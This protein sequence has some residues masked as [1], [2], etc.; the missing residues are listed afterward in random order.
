MIRL[1]INYIRFQ[2]Q[3]I[4]HPLK[5]HSQAARVLEKLRTDSDENG[6]KAK[7]KL[8]IE[9]KLEAQLIY[10]YNTKY[11]TRGF[12]KRQ[13]DLRDEEYVS[14]PGLDIDE[15]VK[16]FMDEEGN[17]N[18]NDKTYES[19]KKNEE[20]ENVEDDNQP[21][22]PY[23]TPL[24][25]VNETT[26]DTSGMTASQFFELPGVAEEMIQLLDVTTT[27]KSLKEKGTDVETKELKHYVRCKRK[28][29]RTLKSPCIL[30]VV[31]LSSKVISTEK[32]FCDSVFVST[33]DD[34]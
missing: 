16:D 22:D 5:L 6:Q 19:P 7:I 20:N 17:E 27:E 34:E 14:E 13:T 25:T 26:V 11:E 3:Q 10:V 1:T 29:P 8:S 2:S 31:S 28:L 4:V 24:Q 9:R 21:D 12:G 23:K 15:M 33:R 32:D 18:W 30:R